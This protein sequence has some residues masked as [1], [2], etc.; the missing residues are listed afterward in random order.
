M[1]V[2]AALAGWIALRRMPVRLAAFPI[3][4]LAAALKVYPA[5]LLILVL[6]ER[7]A[8]C[9]AVAVICLAALLAYAAIDAVGLREMLAV[10]PGGTP[11][12]YSFGVGNLPSGLRVVF[13]WPPVVLGPVTAKLC[14]MAIC[15]V[16]SAV[17]LP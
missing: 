7:L 13:G 6:R 15:P 8:L 12:I 9:L 1:F 11:F 17:V 14:E 10:V 5:T 2:L 3:V 4:L 16:S